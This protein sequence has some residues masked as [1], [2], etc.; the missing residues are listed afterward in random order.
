M[1]GLLKESRHLQAIRCGLA[2]TAITAGG[3]NDKDMKSVARGTT[4]LNIKNITSGA[5]ARKLRHGYHLITKGMK[6][7]RLIEQGNID[8]TDIGRLG[9]EIIVAGIAKKGAMRQIA[10][11]GIVFYFDQSNKV[12]QLVGTRQYLLPYS[13]DLPQYFVDVQ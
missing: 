12:G 8:A 3:M 10:Q 1:N 5:H 2:G 7:L 6:T 4:A 9:H 11:H 13:I